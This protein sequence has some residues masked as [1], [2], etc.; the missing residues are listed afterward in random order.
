MFIAVATVAAAALAIGLTIAC[1]D[2]PG[3]GG[4]AMDS[5]AV[6]LSVSWQHLG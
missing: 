3:T 1:V 5:A 4:M 6:T 2:M